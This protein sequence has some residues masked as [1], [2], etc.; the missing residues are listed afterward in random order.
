MS[1]EPYTMQGDGYREECPECSGTGSVRVIYGDE[2]GA[3]PCLS[4][5]GYGHVLTRDELAE[6]PDLRLV[7]EVEHDERDAMGAESGLEAA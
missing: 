4:C 7:P 5:G 3:A 2:E 6:L 1:D